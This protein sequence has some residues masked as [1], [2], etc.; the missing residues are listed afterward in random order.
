M[1]QTATFTCTALAGTN[2]AGVIKPDEDGYYTLVLG[3]LNIYNS[4]GA[5][6]P[7]ESAKHIFKESSSLMR[8]IANGACRGEYGHPKKKPGQSLRDYVA[9][10]L[11]I[12]EEMVC[13]HFKEVSIDY[14]SIKD[15]NGLPVIAVIGKVKPCGPKGSFL[16]ESLENPNENVSF[17]VRSMTDD[18]FQNGQLVKNIR[19]IVTWDYVNEPGISV[20]SKY[21]APGLEDFEETVFSAACLGSIRDYQQEAVGVSMESAGVVSAESVLAEL[22]WSEQPNR[23]DTPA[24][25]KW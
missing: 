25:A 15:R 23:D 8:R 11:T 17:S 9:R 10:I 18:F 6:Y 14:S 12:E 4:A 24:W 16:K 13:C 22:G 2:K 19:T 21:S 20:A 7:Y 3:A 5:F 1:G